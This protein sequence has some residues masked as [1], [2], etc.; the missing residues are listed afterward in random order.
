MTGLASLVSDGGVR[1]VGWVLVHSLWQGA[2]VALAVGL[3]LRLVSRRHA[4]VRYGIAVA[5][6][7]ACV[8]G[9]A[10][11]GGK[12][13]TDWQM[14][15]RCWQRAAAGALSTDDARRCGS[16][17]VFAKASP[18]AGVAAEA[19]DQS[20]DIIDR[21]LRAALALTPAAAWATVLWL[22]GL[23][24]LAVRF[25]SDLLLVRRLRLNARSVHGDASAHP[26]AARAAKR[27]GLRRPVTLGLC[28]DMDTPCVVGC[29][30][31]LVLLPSWVT[32]VLQPTEL[33]PILAHEFAHVRRSD[34]AA[35]LAQRG[36]ETVFFFNPFVRWISRRIR[37]EREASCDRLAAGPTP[38]SLLLYIS[39]LS[40][41]ER[42]RS[43]RRIAA[44]GV[45]LHGGGDLLRRVERLVETSSSARPA[46]RRL[47]LRC[48]LCAVGL[49][50][51]AASWGAAD[52]V[53]RALSSYS[54]MTVDLRHREPLDQA[55][56][57]CTPSARSDG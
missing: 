12:L 33:E 19:A 5:G 2:L 30:R 1:T 34:Y 23:A 49:A 38:A 51:A 13:V 42:L 57:C 4:G 21:M 48:A 28:A 15:A 47:A 3:C 22:L 45:A 16:H 39:A 56:V 43:D 27:V 9:M 40:A 54:V 46:P 10:A 55:Q 32:G 25:V 31:P 26:A 36:I 24:M 18:G 35:N 52:A 37:E 29:T 6:L 53:A 20:P 11:T 8:V 7:A 44:P 50:A 41:V 14:H 17:G